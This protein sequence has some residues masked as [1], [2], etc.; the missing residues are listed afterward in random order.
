[1]TLTVSSPA[2][3]LDKAGLDLG[4]SGWL[5]VT[6]ADVN[7]FADA[8]KDHQWIHVDPERA[9][10]GPFG[11]TIAHGY[12]SL[13]LVIPLWSE[14]LHVENV[15]M[16]IN[17]GLNRLRFPAP[18]PV[19]SRVRLA[20]KLGSVSEVTGGIEVVADLTMEVEGSEKP[21]LVAEAVYRFYP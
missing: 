21:A 10:S 3:L 17:Y 2:E 19:G 15:G 12:M 1:M 14:L 8:T 6:Q 16:S 7:L 18:V 4:T 13:A 11:R 20:G 5:E 9:A